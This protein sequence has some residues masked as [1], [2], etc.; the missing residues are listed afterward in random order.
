[1]GFDGLG[2]VF[3]SFGTTHDDT[4]GRCIDAV[5]AELGTALPGA[6]LAQAYTSSIVR[7][8]LAHRSGDG[9]NPVPDACGA[10][11]GLAARGVREVV[12]QPGHLMPG[13][14]YEKLRRQVASCESL[15]ERVA[16]GEPLLAGTDDVH[17]LVDIV[18]AEFPRQEGRAIVLM[19][20][21]TDHFANVV[22]EAMNFYAGLIGRDDLLIGTVEAQPDLETLLRLLEERG[23]R[24]GARADAAGAVEGPR[25]RRGFERVTLAPLMLVAGDHATNDMAGEGPDSWASRLHAAGYD[26]TCVLRGLGELPE[27]RRMYVEKARAAA[28]R[29]AGHVDAAGSEGAGR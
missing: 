11:D 7:R 28:A 26:V 25:D 2:V 5:A 27:V 20:H 14:E 1:M 10:L 4:R 21:G 15:F 24:G 17:R 3:A 23:D 22:Y 6:S 29:L 12:V 16:V 9:R 13:H 18:A 19:G 8:V